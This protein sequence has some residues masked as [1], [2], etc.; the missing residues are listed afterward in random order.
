MFKYKPKLTRS[1][2]YSFFT[3]MN[4]SSAEI[5]KAVRRCPTTV[6]KITGGLALGSTG[7]A[8]GF[9]G[10]SVSVESGTLLSLTCWGGDFIFSAGSTVREP[11]ASSKGGARSNMKK[12]ARRGGRKQSENSGTELTLTKQKLEIGAADGSGE[13]KRVVLGD[14][15]NSMGS[16]A[17][18]EQPHRE[19]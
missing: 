15:S 11:E 14:V 1:N 9:A 19:Q 3:N 4:S 2:A 10:V 5:H 13:R 17:V 8:E 6:T 7:A 18:F 12:L 16:A